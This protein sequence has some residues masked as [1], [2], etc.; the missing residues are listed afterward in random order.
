MERK[1]TQG[2]GPVWLWFIPV[3]LGCLF[4]LHY[5]F[6]HLAYARG[7]S[8]SAYMRGYVR[9]VGAALQQYRVEYGEMPQGTNAEIT[10]KLM[11]QNP[12]KIVFLEQQGPNRL[13]SRGELVDI[14]DTPYRFDFSSPD[15]PRVWSCGPNRKDEN[16]A[17]GSDD[18]VSWR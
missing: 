10:S 11:G 2:R 18:I 17:E 14:W 1:L 3:S 15:M 4:A 12:R 9:S 13:N 16:G 8:K 5:A 6:F 7:I